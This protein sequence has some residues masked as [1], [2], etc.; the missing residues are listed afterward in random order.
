MKVESV[1]PCCGGG[2]DPYYPD[3]AT[4]P[5]CHGSGKL[6]VDL[7]NGNVAPVETMSHST[8]TADKALYEHP[9]LQENV[10]DRAAMLQAQRAIEEA[11]YALIESMDDAL[12]PVDDC[13]AAKTR[14]PEWKPLQ[15]ETLLFRRRHVPPKGIPAYTPPRDPN[16]RYI[17]RAFV[18]RKGHRR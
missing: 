9:A 8:A 4:C 12:T 6:E 14:L 17:V 7:D 13:Y 5:I 16:R 10:F 2:H 1:C 11:Y 15:R 3:P 18:T